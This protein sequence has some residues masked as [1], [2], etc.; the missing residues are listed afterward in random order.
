[1]HGTYSNYRGLRHDAHAPTALLRPYPA[2]TDEAPVTVLEDIAQT[3][4]WCLACHGGFYT[5]PHRDANGMCTTFTV[6]SG[7]KMWEFLVPIKGPMTMK[8]RRAWDENMFVKDD[9]PMLGTRRCVVTL[10]PGSTVCVFYYS[11]ILV[12]LIYTGKISV[13]CLPA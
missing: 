9:R 11:S 4:A 2:T 12:Q 6:M 8:Q 5:P 7:L 10:P 1:M 3:E 13:S